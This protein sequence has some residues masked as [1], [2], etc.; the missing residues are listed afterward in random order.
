VHPIAREKG[1]TTEGDDNGQEHEDY[2]TV[3]GSSSV[4][5]LI[6]LRFGASL[7]LAG[8]VVDDACGLEV[9]VRIAR[10]NNA[11]VGCGVVVAPLCEVVVVS[12]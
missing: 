5:E 3:R 11:V 9:V 7:N 10:L 2:Y 6:V 8:L 12:L 4:N 1:G